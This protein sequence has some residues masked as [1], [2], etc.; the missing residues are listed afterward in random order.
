MFFVVF[1]FRSLEI[2]PRIGEGLDMR[3]QR[4]N[5]RVEF[6][7]QTNKCNIDFLLS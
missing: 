3:Q 6:I 7:L 4:L 2:E 5:K 1:A